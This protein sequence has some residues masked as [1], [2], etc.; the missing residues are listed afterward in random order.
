M[1]QAPNNSLMR[2]ISVGV[3]PL[4]SQAPSAGPNV[5]K[6]F[7]DALDPNVSKAPDGSPIHGGSVIAEPLSSQVQSQS[8]I[9]KSSDDGFGLGASA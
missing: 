2:G 3:E 6:L 8:N 7:D 5:E 4:T 9:I 1:N